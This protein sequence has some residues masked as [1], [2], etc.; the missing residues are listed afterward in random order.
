MIEKK[1][2]FISN[3]IVGKNPGV[4]GGE[5]RF[6]ELGKYWQKMGFEIHLVSSEGGKTLCEKMG[7]PVILHRIPS[8]DTESRMEMIR[9][10]FGLIWYIPQILSEFKSGVIYSTSE[11][12]YD[13]LPASFL[14]LFHGSK[15]RWA[16]AVHWLP[17]ILFWRRK[18]SKWYNSL[19]FLISERMGLFFAYLF[20]D[21]MFPV[22]QSTFSDMEKA[23]IKGRKIKV[24]KCGVNLLEIKEITSKI[25]ED[26]TYEAVFMKRIQAV[27]GIFDLIDIWELVVKK[28]PEAKLVVVGSGIDEEEAKRRATEKDLTKNIQFLGAVYDPVEK[29]TYVAKSRLFLL[30]SYEENWAI[31]IGEALACGTPVM[32]YRLKELEEVWQDSITYIELSAKE[33]FAEK[34]IEYLTDLR[35]YEA[36]VSYG[37]EYVKQYDWQE[38]AEEEIKNIL[39]DKNE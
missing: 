32:V 6:I 23:Q 14:K 16:T 20:S 13:V 26:K 39:G 4:S 29:C 38:I 27:K 7:L 37:L 5:S 34:I 22:S 19:M 36:K 8:T 33:K 9:R 24:V 3:S 18:S 1:V 11:Q 2:L 25:S 17:P 12:I 10:M 15:I 35:E 31:V 21:S 30:P 28:L